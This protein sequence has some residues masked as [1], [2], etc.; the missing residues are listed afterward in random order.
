MLLGTGQLNMPRVEARLLTEA[1][2]PELATKS[3]AVHQHHKVA[4]PSP[5]EQG[6]KAQ[7]LNKKIL[8]GPVCVHPSAC[9]HLFSVLDPL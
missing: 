3:R 4:D 8:E 6:F 9:L 7:P 2:S 1:H 5:A